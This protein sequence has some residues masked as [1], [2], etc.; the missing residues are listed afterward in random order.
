MLLHEVAHVRR[1][2]TWVACLQ[3]AAQ[4]LWWFHPLVWWM[5]R[6]ISRQQERS[7]DKEVVANPQ[8]LWVALNFNA[9]QTKGVY[10]SYD[11]SSKGE[12]SRVG[13]AGDEEEPKETGVGGD[14]MVQVMLPRSATR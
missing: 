2:D 8:K 12:H 11:T 3:L 7:C 4:I 5:N 6:E 9:H 14:W 10:V 1:R 13:L